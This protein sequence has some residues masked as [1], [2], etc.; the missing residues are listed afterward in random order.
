[1]QPIKD[2]SIRELGRTRLKLRGD[3]Q[4]TP[5][6]FGAESCYTIEDPVSS[7]FYRV[8][9]PEYT[10]IS[11]LDGHTSISQALALAVRA[12]PDV[13]F[14][15][16]EAA[17]ICKWLIESELAATTESAQP[18]RLAETAEKGAL[19]RLS[20]IWNPAVIR[21][22]IFRPDRFLQALTPWIS[23]LYTPTAFAAWVLLILAASYS[24]VSNWN[25][26]V[27]STRGVFAPGN[28]LWLALCWIVLKL[29][30]EVSH[31]AVCKR[32]GGSVREAGVML[33]MLAPVA[34]VDV[35]SS[36][37]FCSKWQ[38]IQTAAAGIYIELLLAAIAAFVWI[39]TDSEALK[40]VC[41]NAMLMA[42]FTTIVFNANPLMKFDGYYMLSDI[43]EIPNLY[44]SG[45]LYLQYWARRYLLGVPGV[46]PQAPSAKRVAI[47][48]YGVASLLWRIVFSVALVLAAATLFR[49]AGI[50]LSILAGAMWLGWPALRFLHY[51]IWGT[52]MEQPNRVRFFWTAGIGSAT[53][54]LLLTALPWPG[55]M[56]APAVVEYSP[57]TAV[58]TGCAGFVRRVFVV[59]GEVVAE[60]QPLVQL[61]NEELVAELA[62]LHLAQQQSQL[63]LRAHEKKVHLA[64]HQAEQENL[65]ALETKCREKQAQVEQLVLR[66]PCDGTIIGRNLDTW[67]GQY[68][69]VGTELLCIGIESKLELRL[70][71]AQENVDA[72]AARVE[73]SIRVRLPGTRAFSCPLTRVN[74]GATID[75][76][77]PSLAAAN[78]G[79]LPVRAKDGA[80][81]GKDKLKNTAVEFELLSPRFTGIMSPSAEQSR[82]LHAGQL[83][84]ATI[85][86][87]D[88]SLGKHLLRVAMRWSEKK[89]NRSF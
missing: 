38:R 28:W 6:S 17:A 57:L 69:K 45:Q 76:Q 16:R 83:G 35:T 62:D 72:F 59:P 15:E 84:L 20:Q 80:S 39:S 50:I 73:E 58:R 2:T 68:T 88:E 18:G 21:V 85:R 23:W 9:I 7:K 43:L 67:L 29:L 89:L 64:A 60:G 4:F 42:S 55:A 3:L 41:C 70:S 86:P 32:Y 10:F 26:F 47:Q 56:H 27:E 34:Y 22:P 87:F 52:E 14:T 79:P 25:Q 49:G 19:A 46:P 40:A 53:L 75:L 1:V 77:Y 13:A 78:G 71:I 5:R 44:A 8:G 24:V 36:W 81:T 48:L 74:P 54:T 37:R 65:K 61:E 63:K 33:I 12:N 66:A 11:L 31:G 51:L 30:H 82:S